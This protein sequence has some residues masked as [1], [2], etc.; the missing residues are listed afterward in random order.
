MTQEEFLEK[1]VFT[2]LQK[3]E[4]HNDCYFSEEDFSE[5]L[6]QCE[7][8]GIAVYDIKTTLNGDAHK[9]INHD[10]FRKKATDV[11][12]YKREYSHLKHEQAGLLYAAT[13][14]VS[15]K[16]LAR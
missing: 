8:F 6:K 5:V 3:N 1:N 11:N 15:K 2:G 7:H 12:W 4:E 9:T 13:Y 16:L 10:S 14:K